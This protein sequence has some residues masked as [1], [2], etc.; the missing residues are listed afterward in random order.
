MS[1]R[2][3][4]QLICYDQQNIDSERDEENEKCMDL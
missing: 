3:A 4:I 1:Y 2:K